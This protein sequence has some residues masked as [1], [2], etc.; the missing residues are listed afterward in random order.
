M[1]ARDPADHDEG[2]LDVGVRIVKRF[3]VADA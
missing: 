1:P 2:I 3:Q